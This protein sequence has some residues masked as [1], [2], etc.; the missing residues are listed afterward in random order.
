M[1]KRGK[2]RQRDNQRLSESSS[3][4]AWNLPSESWF[5]EGNSL[6]FINY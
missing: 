1:P 4:L 3:K 6:G 5:A 2:H